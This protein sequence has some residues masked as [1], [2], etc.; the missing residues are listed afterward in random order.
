M[1]REEYRQKAVGRYYL[2][3]KNEVGTEKLDAKLIEAYELGAM[4]AYDEF[5]KD[6]KAVRVPLWDVNSNNFKIPES[7]L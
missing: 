2:Q 7:K 5:H 3:K 4:Q 1:T 6:P